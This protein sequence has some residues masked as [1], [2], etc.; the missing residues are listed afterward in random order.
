MY[1]APTLNTI[2]II[3]KYHFKKIWETEIVLQP[4]LSQSKAI[5]LVSNFCSFQS[6]FTFRIYPF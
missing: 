5:R 3:W 6:D 4:N 2:N 1:I